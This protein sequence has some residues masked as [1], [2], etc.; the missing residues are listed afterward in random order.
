MKCPHCDQEIP[1]SPCPQCDTV[2]P[3]DA[4]FCMECGFSPSGDAGDA[5]EE[6]GDVEEDGGF[7]LDDRVLCPD[8][9]CTGIL[10]DGK[11]TECGDGFEK[12]EEETQDQEVTP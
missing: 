8:G 5:A 6:Y 9:T 2:V 3:E 4:K 11:C 12:K 10:I 7:D 1:G